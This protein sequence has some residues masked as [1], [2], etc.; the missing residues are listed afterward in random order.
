MVWSSVIS[1]LSILCL[2]LCVCL[3]DSAEVEMS[4]DDPPEIL[5]DD[6]RELLVDDPTQVPWLADGLCVSWVWSGHQ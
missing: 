4:V 2:S 3:V 1:H 5:V 6:D